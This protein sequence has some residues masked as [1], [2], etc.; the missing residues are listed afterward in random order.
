MFNETMGGRETALRN[1]EVV[2]VTL[3]SG[4]IRELR[5]QPAAVHLSVSAQATDLKLGAP[6]AL[7]TMR[8]SYLEWLAEHH[9]LR[10]AWGS[11]AWLFALIVGGSKWW[12]G[13][14][15]S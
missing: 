2:D 6:N 1:R 5:L 10:L 14:G 12:Q 8:P 15:A 3:R 7:Q 11:A 9:G 13:S 4:R